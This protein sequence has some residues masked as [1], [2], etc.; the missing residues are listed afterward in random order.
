MFSVQADRVR[1]SISEPVGPTRARKGCRPAFGV[2][3]GS[4]MGE[5][6][7]V[8]GGARS[9]KSRLAARLAAEADGP[10]TYVATALLDPADPD[11][12]ARINRHRAERPPSWTL[13]EVPRDLEGTLPTLVA[14]GGALIV[15]CVT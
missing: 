12:A 8:L 9:G 15:D 1:A 11:F 10:V 7:L 2:G 14:L 5:M 4:G 3:E 6:I 13:A